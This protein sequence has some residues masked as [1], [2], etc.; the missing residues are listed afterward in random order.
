MTT[1]R[2]RE[3]LACYREF[4]QTRQVTGSRKDFGL[5]G[6]SQPPESQATVSLSLLLHKILKTSIWCSIHVHRVVA[7]THDKYSSS[8]VMFAAEAIYWRWLKWMSIK[9]ALLILHFEWH[10]WL[11]DPWALKTRL[12]MAEQSIP[13]TT[14]AACVQNPGQDFSVILKD[15]VPVPKPGEWCWNVILKVHSELCSAGNREVLLKLSVTGICYSDLHYM[16]EVCQ[17]DSGITHTKILM[18]FRIFRWRR[19]QKTA[20]FHQAMKVLERSLQLVQMSQKV[21]ASRLVIELASSPFTLLVIHA[22]CALLIG[23]W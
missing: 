18:I 9:L 17:L 6:Y 4:E 10:C 23:R 15:D 11:A 20:S 8:S 14:R 13:S 22:W 5:G 7:S 16:L 3:C 21:S 12:K 2:N 1:Q 19:C